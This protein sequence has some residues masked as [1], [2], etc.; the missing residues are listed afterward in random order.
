MEK[1][2]YENLLE[3]SIYIYIYYHILKIYKKIFLFKYL[4]IY[5][6]FYIYLIF[7]T[8]TIVPFFSSNPSIIVR[9]VTI[10]NHKFLFNHLCTSLKN[11]DYN[12]KFNF[13]LLLATLTNDNTKKWNN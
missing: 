2:L 11:R 9:I 7:E 8:S 5:N 6:I 12:K 13:H 3:R 4:S 1:N 10:R